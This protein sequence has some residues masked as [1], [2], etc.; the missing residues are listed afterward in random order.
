MPVSS[1]PP[2]HQ[3]FPILGHKQQRAETIELIGKQWFVSNEKARI[4]DLDF[5]KVLALLGLERCVGG[6]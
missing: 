6:L 5:L 2:L 3:A 4:N 1:V